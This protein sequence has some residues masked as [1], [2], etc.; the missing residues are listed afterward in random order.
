MPLRQRVPPRLREFLRPSVS[1]EARA[2][3]GPSFSQAGEDRIVRFLFDVIGVTHPTYLDVGAYHPFNLSNTALLSLNGS[4]GV[5][6]EPDPDAIAAFSRH[7]P[8][9]V[10][11]NIGVGPEAGSLTFYRMSLPTLNT[12]DREAAERVRESSGGVHDIVGTVEVEVRTMAGVIADV[13]RCPEFLTL[14]AEGLDHAILQTM[15]TWPGRPVVVCVELLAY[16]GVLAHA[17]RADEIPRLMDELGYAM[18]AD[19]WVNGVFVDKQR[20]R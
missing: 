20:W 4:L 17:T 18:L 2:W 19:T 5:N 12:F 11:L 15:P 13:G 16:A 1:A 6:V 7:R 3:L 10:N 9:D 8:R 14:D